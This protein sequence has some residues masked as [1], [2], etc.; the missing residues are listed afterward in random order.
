MAGENRCLTACEQGGSTPIALLDICKAKAQDIVMGK[1]L[2]LISSASAI[3]CALVGGVLEYL[4]TSGSERWVPLASGLVGAIAGG[5]VG[6]FL[7][8]RPS[9][10]SRQEVGPLPE[11]PPTVLGG[12]SNQPLDMAQPTRYN[13]TQRTPKEL[14]QSVNGKT[15]MEADRI[16]E[17]YKD[18]LLE[19]RAVVYDV[20]SHYDYIGVSTTC[21]GVFVSL[22]FDKDKYMST[23]QTLDKGDRIHAIGRIWRITRNTVGLVDCELVPATPPN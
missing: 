22:D 13:F 19:V 9:V 18:S 15:S 14:V 6:L 7:M 16:S 12:V 17:R 5:S 20:H 2:A 23:L 3:L 11:M 8:P 4:L 1:R 10:A 21:N